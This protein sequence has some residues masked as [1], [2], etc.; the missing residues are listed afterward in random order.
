LVLE[1]ILALEMALEIVGTTMILL[2]RI[3]CLLL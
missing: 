2:T 3:P 1:I